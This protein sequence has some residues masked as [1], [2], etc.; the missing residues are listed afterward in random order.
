M[1]TLNEFLLEKLDL[2]NVVLRQIPDDIK[3][4]ENIESI[5]V[6]MGQLQSFANKN[7]YAI[8]FRDRLTRNGDFAIPIYEY[9][10]IG[11]T[12][13]K[14]TIAFS[15]FW[16]NNR[17]KPNDKGFQKCYMEAVKWIVKNSR[18]KE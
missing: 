16:L 18:A 7:G 5:S 13:K 12:A 4:F 10:G 17:K 9:N 8:S 3:D 11:H 14:Q 1:K 2:D 6:K 15:G